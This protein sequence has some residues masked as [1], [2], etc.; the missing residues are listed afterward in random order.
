MGFDNNWAISLE[1]LS[2]L[3]ALEA[4]WTD[5]ERRTRPSFFQTWGWIGSWIK[6]LPDNV[7]L[8]VLTA[9]LNDRVVGLAMLTLSQQRRNG[10]V[11]SKI[12]SFN[13]TGDANLDGITIEHNGVMIQTGLEFEII[14]RI[15]NWLERE[16]P[17]WDEIVIR[18]IDSVVAE[19]YL[20]TV[21]GSKLKTKL[22]DVSPYYFVDLAEI[23]N[24]ESDYLSSLSR[25]TRYQIRRA[26]KQYSSDGPV[27]IQI[28]ESID[29]AI[30]F[31]DRLQKLH[32]QYWTTKGHTGAF[33]DEFRQ[34][35]HQN[36]IRSRFPRGEI[37]LIEV[38]AGDKPFGYLY[39]FCHDGIISNYQS[40]FHYQDNMKLK[41]G[42]VSHSLAI[43]K[44]IDGQEIKYDF[45]MGQHR[46]K[47]SLANRK[48]D[49]GS[50]VYQKPRLRFR[51]EATL[52][53]FRNRLRANR[54]D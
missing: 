39:N 51:I 19:P 32:Q 29:E 12:L 36:L 47:S 4:D 18:G 52:R 23:R 2:S 48:G 38:C 10:F 35:L 30:L 41:P 33:G 3:E 21:P 5:L 22:V 16:Q 44:Y 45:L 20:T 40:G 11:R 6:A 42:L 49:M 53:D 7:S 34:R 37:H 26:I 50:L 24:T 31:F 13:E 15:I 1:P 9:R 8:L 28:A 14:P 43:Q 46:Y 27:R 25:N 54:L 17:G